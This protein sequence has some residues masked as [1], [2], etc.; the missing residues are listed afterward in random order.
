MF[1]GFFKPVYDSIDVFIDMAYLTDYQSRRKPEWILNDLEEL[2]VDSTI[3][4]C[5]RIPN[6]NNNAAAFGALYVLEGSTLGGM[7]IRRIISDKLHIN[8]GLTFFSGYG[9]Q[10]RERWNVFIHAMNNM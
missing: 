7:V 1:Y 5:K 4:L 3:K 2:E 9:K 8:K 10:T 6:I